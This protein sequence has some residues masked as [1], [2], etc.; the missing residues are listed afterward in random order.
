MS[1]LL[2][3]LLPLVLLFQLFGCNVYRQNIM[4]QT[5]GNVNADVLRASA[6]EA[7]KNYRVQPNDIL[8]IKIF[9]NKGELLVDPN[10][11]L[12]QE[13]TSGSGRGGVSQQGQQIEDPDYNVLPNGEV[14][15]PMVGYVKVDGLT[16]SQVDSLLQT[17]FETY[18]KETYVY[19]KVVSRRVVVLGA[20]GGKVIPLNNESMHLVEVIALAGGVPDNGKAHNIRLIR[21]VASD[22]P[23]VEIIDLSTVQGLQRAN[24]WVQPNDVIYVEP[25]RRVFNESLRDALTVLGALSNILTTYLVI[26]NLLN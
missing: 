8:E 13:L 7:S 3:R 17:Q 19:T 18:Y 23:S 25:V 16:V 15:V 14:K 24:I 12:R 2:L 6:A 21:N 22:N 26:E 9:T 4:F 10:N 20:T 5:D 1:K 11:F